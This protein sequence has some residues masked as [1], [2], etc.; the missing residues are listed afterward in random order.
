MNKAY[1]TKW[2]NRNIESRPEFEVAEEKNLNKQ[3]T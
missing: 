2:L 1:H 3:N